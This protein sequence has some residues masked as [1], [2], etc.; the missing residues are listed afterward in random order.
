MRDAGS[1]VMVPPGCGPLCPSRARRPLQDGAGAPV[2]DPLS[3]TGVA[4]CATGWRDR[5]TRRAGTST[6]I[7]SHWRRRRANPARVVASGCADPRTLRRIMDSS[8]AGRL[9][10]VARRAT[11]VRRDRR[12][13]GGSGPTSPSSAAGFTGLWTAI[14]AARDRPRAARRRARGGPGRLGRERPQRRVLRGVADPRPPQRDPPLPGRARGPRGRG[15][16]ATCASSS[17]SSATRASTASS[18]RPARSTSRPS[19][20]RSTELRASTSSSPPGTA[21]RSTFLD[22]EA[23]QAEVHSPR[24]LAGVRRRAPTVRDGQPGQARV[25]ASPRRRERAR[26]ADRGGLTG[27]AASSDG[28]AASTSRRRRRHRRGGPR[29]R[30]ARPRTARWLRRLAPD[31]RAR[32]RL[33]AH[34][35]AADAGQRDAIGWARPRG[36]VRRGQPVPLLPAVGRRPDPVGRLRRDLPP[37]QRGQARATTRGRRRSTSSARHFVETFPQLDGIRSPH[38]WGG[39]IDT[40]TRFSV[41][42]GQTLGGRVHYALGYTG[43]GV[44]ASRWAAGILRDIVLRPDS[45]LLRL[46]FVRSR[47]FPIPPEPARTPAVELM[48][49]SVIAADSNEGRRG[50]PPGDG[51]ARDRLR[52]VGPRSRRGARGVRSPA[53]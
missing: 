32:L 17:R 26:R 49:R 23:I 21:R 10:L 11:P 20:G 25:G 47:P 41:T 5:A 6:R 30:R 43:L 24:F 42:F 4:G 51:R 35:R 37:R 9:V 33:R 53:P 16:R 39:A 31:V 48:R 40:T 19:R 28:P 27:H 1:A 18:R 22:R 12:S 8:A 38:R 45:D 15:R 50:V 2:P 14:R 36:H 29:A 34:D 7:S 3:G 44:G 46:R 13:T 52:L